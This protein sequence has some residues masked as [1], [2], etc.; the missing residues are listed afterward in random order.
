MLSYQQ[1]TSVAWVSL[2]VEEAKGSCPGKW[3]VCSHKSKCLLKP[4]SPFPSGTTNILLGAVNSYFWNVHPYLIGGRF[5]FLTFCAYFSDG[6]LEI[7]NH[8]VSAPVTKAGCFDFCWLG[9]HFRPKSC[10]ISHRTGRDGKHG[11]SESTINHLVT[12]K[13]IGIAGFLQWLWQT[14]VLAENHVGP[15]LDSTNLCF[16]FPN[17]QSFSKSS[18]NI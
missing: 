2:Q 3:V 11:Y 6:L 9:H 16:S 15:H 17:C 10:S 7:T 18:P 14:P 8:S 4:F 12:S 5:P 13:L 1:Y